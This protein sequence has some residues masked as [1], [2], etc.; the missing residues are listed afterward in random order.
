MYYMYTCIGDIDDIQRESSD[1][2]LLDS[3]RRT[4]SP[5]KLPET[6]YFVENNCHRP[7]FSPLPPI[8]ERSIPPYLDTFSL[9]FVNGKINRIPIGSLPPPFSTSSC[10]GWTMAR[11]RWEVEKEM[12]YSCSNK[13]FKYVEYLSKNFSQ[14]IF[15][16]F[17]FFFFSIR[18]SS[19]LPSMERIDERKGRHSFER[20]RSV[21]RNL[22]RL[23]KRIL[24]SSIL[25]GSARMS[26]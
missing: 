24:K 15:T 12:S 1:H 20:I 23:N 19:L 25:A 5:W 13:L 3:R 10:T 16:Y 11:E 9:R 22:M 21:G 4:N 14:G 17:F 8:D 6:C 26:G 7:P 18:F 2:T